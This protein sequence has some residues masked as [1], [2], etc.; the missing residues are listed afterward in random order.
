MVWLDSLILI[1][2]RESRLGSFFANWATF[3]TLYD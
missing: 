1:D 3:G 2:N